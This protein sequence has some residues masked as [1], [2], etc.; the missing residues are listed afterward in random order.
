MKI[1]ILIESRQIKKEVKRLG[2]EITSD[3]HDKNPVIISVLKSAFIFTADLIREF[4]FPFEIEFI[5]A[6]SY[7]KD[8]FS[9]SVELVF[10]SH[11]NIS[12][13][14]VLIVDDILDSGN[15]LKKIVDMFKEEIGNISI[16]GTDWPTKDKKK[17]NPEKVA[18]GGFLIDIIAAIRQEKASQRIALN[19]PLKQ[20]TITVPEEQIEAVKKNQ[21]LIKMPTH[22]S[23]LIVKAGSE[24]TIK[25]IKE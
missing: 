21:N 6:K 10:K 17:Y 20:V 16:H 4:S 23:K 9:G 13:K 12:G 22:I 1:D 19:Q 15:T 24:L 5:R 2:K 3:F 11:F 14:H 18:L 7:D 25:I 8:I